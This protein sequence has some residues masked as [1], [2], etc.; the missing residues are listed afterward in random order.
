MYIQFI[1]LTNTEV[2]P[3]TFSPFELISSINELKLAKPLVIHR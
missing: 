2:E 1:D 3:I